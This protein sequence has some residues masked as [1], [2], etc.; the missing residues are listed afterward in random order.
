MD[1]HF[2]VSA[3]IF[4]INEVIPN[5]PKGSLTTSSWYKFEY[6]NKKSKIDFVWWASLAFTAG[7]AVGFHGNFTKERILKNKR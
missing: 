6:E 5:D 2:I 1:G 4:F 7:F 3:V